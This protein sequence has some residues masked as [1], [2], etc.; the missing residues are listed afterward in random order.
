MFAHVK[1]KYTTNQNTTTSNVPKPAFQ[2]TGLLSWDPKLLR[3][4]S[5]EVVEK[6]SHRNLWW[7]SE[8]I[9]YEVGLTKILLG[10]YKR[11]NKITA[12][13]TIQWTSSPNVF[14]ISCLKFS[15]IK[16]FLD[17]I[18]FPLQ[19]PSGHIHSVPVLHIKLI[20]SV[21]YFVILI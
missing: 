10:E 19:Y 5:V 17:K 4:L 15:E 7:L 20:S 9:V 1:I 6:Q 18:L 21:A 16:I 12:N 13:K 14:E 11:K 3:L 8:H 2:L